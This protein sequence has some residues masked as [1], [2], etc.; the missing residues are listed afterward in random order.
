MHSL[1]EREREEVRYYAKWKSVQGYVKVYR[2]KNW[3]MAA[4]NFSKWRKFLDEVK[5]QK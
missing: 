2:L 3:K 4:L 5:I 1:K